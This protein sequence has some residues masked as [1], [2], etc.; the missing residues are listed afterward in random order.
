MSLVCL[1]AV[2]LSG[3][4]V[5]SIQPF[6][7]EK[8]V[9]FDKELLG[10]WKVEGKEDTLL[11]RKA[12][13]V[14]YNIAVFEDGKAIVYRGYLFELMRSRYLDITQPD[15]SDSSQTGHMIPVHTLW[16]VE[17]GGDTLTIYGVNG[18]KLRDILKEKPLPWADPDYRGGV[19]LMGTTAQIQEFL[20]QNPNELFDEEGGVWK[21]E[22]H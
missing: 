3:C 10:A 21:R 7:S 16:K 4:V 20:R 22:K 12:D 19:L 17:Y 8:D 6:Y 14:S 18:T 9:V 11:F 13:D 2:F 15:A 5:L 1:L